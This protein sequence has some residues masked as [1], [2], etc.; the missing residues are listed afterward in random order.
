MVL[1]RVRDEDQPGTTGTTVAGPVKYSTGHPIRNKKARPGWIS[2]LRMEAFYTTSVQRLLNFL[3]SC[4]PQ[5]AFLIVRF[6][7]K[8]PVLYCLIVCCS[9]VAVSNSLVQ[10]AP[11]K[12]RQRYLRGNGHGQTHERHEEERPVGSRQP[13]GAA[14]VLERRQVFFLSHAL[15]SPQGTL[16]AAAVLVVVHRGGTINYFPG[17]IGSGPTMHP[18]TH[19]YAY[20]WTP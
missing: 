17:C 2:Y 20:Y 10:D 15:V 9:A 11:C 18:K 14:E 4:K 8:C 1:T 6:L 7:I 13:E 12:V 16:H 5:P 3:F 19:I